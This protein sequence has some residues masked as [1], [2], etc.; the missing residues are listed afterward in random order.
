MIKELDTVVL[1]RDITEYGLK[2][3]DIGAIVNAC[4]DGNGF[5]TE[6]IA[7]NGG[8]IAVVTLMARDIRLMKESEI[9]HVRKLQAA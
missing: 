9:L 6:F 3:G 1:T 7:G 5:E 8:T 2:T 4:K